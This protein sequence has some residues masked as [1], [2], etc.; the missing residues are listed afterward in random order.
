MRSTVDQCHA[1]LAM[2]GFSLG[3]ATFCHAD[4][5]QRGLLDWRMAG[6]VLFGLCVMFAAGP[7]A[8]VARPEVLIGK[9]VAVVDA[10]TVAVLVGTEQHRIRVYGIDC[11]ERGQPFGARARQLIGELAFYKTV[12]VELRDRDRYGRTL[13][14]VRL[15]DGKDLGAEMI[16]AGVAWS[17]EGSGPGGQAYSRMQSEARKAKRGLWSDPNPMPPWEWRAKEREKRTPL[18]RPP[19]AAR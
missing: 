2:L 16:R 15:P 7:G 8:P 3:K 10:E 6:R 12:Q 19:A 18:A 13:G 4:G 17:Y 1:R 9:V 14:R 5:P 11:P